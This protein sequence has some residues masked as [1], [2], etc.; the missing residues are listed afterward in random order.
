MAPLALRRKPLRHS[1]RRFHA[2]VEPLEDRVVP[3]TSPVDPGQILVRF[4]PT[5]TNPASLQLVE[6]TRVSAPLP[7]VSGVW[8]VSLSSGV[9]VDEA[10]AAYRASPLV[11]S[12][13][14]DRIIS[15]TVTPNDPG[16]T[17]TWGLNNTGQTGGTPDADIDAPEAWD[18]ATGAGQI[19]AVLDTGVDFTHPDLA[20]NMWVNPLE[21]VD[22]LDNDG[23]GFIDDIHGADFVNDD[24]NPMDDHYHGTHV[25]G[26]IGAVW[27]NNIGVAGVAPN[28]KIMALKFLDASGSG[29]VSD[30]ILALNYAVSKGAQIS[31]NSYGGPPEP[32][33]SFFIEAIQNAAA[34]GHIFVAGAGNSGT[35]NDAS[36]FN[37]ATY[38]VDNIISVA[39]TDHNDSFASFSNYGR[40]TVDLAAPGVGI[41][42]TSPGNSYRTL[43]GTSMATPHVAGVVAL[44][45]SQNPT[46]SYQQVI[47]QVLSTVDPVLGLQ[48]LVAT[49]GRLNAYRA[50]TSAPGPRVIATNPSGETGAPTSTVRVTF[51]K[52]IDPDSFT[53]DDVTGFTGP[54]GAVTGIAVTAVAGSDRQFDI[55]FDPQTARGAYQ[56]VIGPGIEDTLGNAMNQD[57]DNVSGE[58]GEDA[59]TAGFVITDQLFYHAP[60]L[61]QIL[62]GLVNTPI[63]ITVN[64]DISIADLN[65]QLNISVPDAGFL[66]LS[67]TSPAGTTVFLKNTLT[68]FVGANFQDTVFS[69]EAELPILSGTPPYQGS[70]RPEEA[71]TAFDGQS[72]LG[73]WRLNVHNLWFDSATLNACTLIVAANP[74]RLTVTDV[75]LNEGDAG[76]TLATFTVRLSNAIEDAVSVEYATG[77]GTATAGVDYDAVSGTLTFLPGQPLTQ[78]VTVVVHGDTDDEGDETF[79]LNLSNVSSTATIEDGQGLGTIRNDELA[80]SIGDVTVVEG[81]S[82]TVNAVFT[83][84]LSE[85]SAQTV[86]VT[87]ATADGSATTAGNDY[88]AA[89]GSVIFTPGQ[90][91]KTVIV[92]VKGDTGHED[93]ETFFV[94]L[95]GVTNAQI[96][97]GQGEG[98]ISN[99]D[100]IPLVKVNSVSVTEGN[101]GSKV[102][103]FQVTLSAPSGRT[104]T[105]Q[106]ATA[107]GTAAAGSDY[108]TL[109]GTVTFNPGQTTRNVAVTIL[110]DGDAEGDETLFLNLSAPAY[111]WIMDG[112]GLFTIQ[113]DDA[114]VSIN[115]ISVTEGDSGFTVATFTVE[116]SAVMPVEVSVAYSTANS[117]ASAGNDYLAASGMVTFAPG[118][119][120][121]TISV[122]VVGD[123]RDDPNEGF[124][125]NLDSATHALIADD[126]G[127][128]TITDDDPTPILTVTGSSLYEGL[129]GNRNLTITFSLS[130]PSNQSVSVQ[131]ATADGSATAGSD[132]TAKSGT[133]TLSAGAT[134]GTVSITISGDA[135]AE[136]DETFFVN[137]ANA[138]NA[139]LATSQVTGVILEDDSLTIG[140]V[141]VAE[142]ANG[143]TQATFIVSLAAPVDHDVVVAYST[144]N[145]SASAGV[146]YLAASGTVTIPQGNLQ[147]EVVITVVGDPGS[148]GDETFLVNLD[149]AT[150]AVIADD[151]ATGVIS[152]DDS[153]PV[154]TVSNVSIVEGNSGNKSLVFT[155][156]LS[157]ASGQNVSVAYATANDTATA[158]SDYTAKS[159]NL[160]FSAGDAV[161]TISISI[162]GDT[163][164]EGDESFW[165]NLSNPNGVVLA[166]SQVAG[167]IVND[168]PVAL[169]TVNDVQVTEGNSA[170]KTVNFSVALSGPASQN[171]TVQ[172]STADGTA[173][174]GSDYLAASGT[175][176]FTPG[177]TSRSVT[178]TVYGLT[179]AEAD[180]TFFIN[181]ANPTNAAIHDAQGQGTILNDDTSITISDVT[182]AEG[183]DGLGTATLSVNLSA[184]VAH[185]VRVQYATANG[186]ASSGSDYVQ[187][188]GTVVFAPGQTSQLVT[189]HT[190]GDSRDEADET[191]NVNLTAPVGAQI[192]DTQGRITLTDDDATPSVSVS[193]V[194]ISEGQSGTK[195]VTF[196][197]SLS[198]LSGRTVT[199]NYA[200][201]NGS[202]TAGSDY[203]AKS[204][205]VTINAGSISQNVS[206]TINGDTLAEVNETILL[207]LS[208]PSNAT[209]ADSQGVGTLQDDDGLTISDATVVEGD[210]G[211]SQLVFTVSLANALSDDVSVGWSTANGTASA[212]SDYL[213]ASGTVFLAAGQTSQTVA[214]TVIGDLLDEADNTV[215]VNL[216]N[217]VNAIIADSQGVGTIQDDDAAPSLSVSDVSVAEGNA[218]TKTVTFVVTLSAESGQT[219]NVSY[220]TANGTATAGSDYVAVSGTLS[221]GAGVTSRNV[222]VTVNADMEVEGNEAFLLDLFGASNAVIT[223][224]QGQAEIF[225]DDGEVGGMLALGATSG[226]PDN[227]GRSAA[228][229][230]SLLKNKK[231]DFE[232]FWRAAARSPR[233][234]WLG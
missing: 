4:K 224:A 185:E 230:I 87:Y 35:D 233:S 204:G 112:Q 115:D 125:V 54:D 67:L 177:Q 12:A 174:A 85:I 29:S 39:A 231:A 202:A 46:W 192:T 182:V 56:L 40:T 1:P 52:A 20:A 27:N 128:A 118:Q 178:I 190:I 62:P 156:S 172:W 161:Q 81:N 158:G 157:A 19:V 92:Q 211:V 43:D 225:D 28:V 173:S 65:V 176:T 114:S 103:N 210:D 149:S 215:L 37:P 8:V 122:L 175:V 232:Q 101:S 194:S 11:V 214:V 123:Q 30:A 100:A 111:A 120:S 84:T 53:A 209:I 93:P 159:G 208:N 13:Q 143:A 198:A 97:D 90:L 196:V 47:D 135:A 45:R 119:T 82:G 150:G 34:A 69:D 221:F 96:I 142:G 51:S 88:T 58:P 74:P 110:G 21:T 32:D 55:T 170:S 146:D 66:R 169:L 16:Y 153:Q 160:T 64:D 164:A 140:D 104:V 193:D 7:L 234:H 42:S 126:Q 154:L 26:T 117:G 24:G 98:S 72:T 187:S 136:G 102:V 165:L 186:T 99:D 36:P 197:V 15:L 220:A 152:N 121:Q 91:T 189:V 57:G 14:A 109:S 205:V 168:E 60:N 86:T 78:T 134:T 167:T 166:T 89:S 200:T 6:G 181:L 138:S 141:T 183:P 131:Y 44:V 188:A 9:T 79:F 129:T 76:E 48:A 83:V 23:N 22:G 3:S 171:V 162:A 199:V 63:S 226:T 151:Q 219:V 201:A 61:P 228:S 191:I 155:L 206:I 71:L 213:A 227:G 113:N 77:G 124:V 33:D 2:Q 145:G 139:T 10:L 75:T 179:A 133:Y 18:I 5:V 203:V 70:Y 229:I 80:V 38:P 195:N 184:A 180:E 163:V 127:L 41:Y 73:V 49:G 217:A 218:G 147:A 216:S 148:E 25:A 68:P 116:L 137:L 222:N 108:T 59:Y 207:N 212:G 31:N 130:A 106:Y 105:V 144:A 94:N 50:L 95:T 223:D 132:Y 17:D 107:D